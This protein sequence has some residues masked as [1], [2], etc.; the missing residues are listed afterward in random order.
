MTD[1]NLLALVLLT[2]YG[3]FSVLH[4]LFHLI[5]RAHSR[6]AERRNRGV[7]QEKGSVT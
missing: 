2:L 7:K 6:M 5:D 4:F 3:L 1:P